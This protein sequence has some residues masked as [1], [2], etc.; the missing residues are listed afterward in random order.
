VNTEAPVS[1]Q[2]E[3]MDGYEFV[4][5]RAQLNPWRIRIEVRDFDGRARDIVWP[6]QSRRN[7]ATTWALLP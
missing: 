7:D 6:A 5:N 3:P 4:I 2:I 1:E